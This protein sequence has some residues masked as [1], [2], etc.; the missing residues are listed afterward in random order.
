MEPVVENCATLLQAK[1]YVVLQVTDTLKITGYITVW[2]LST[3]FSFVLF[4]ILNSLAT[5]FFVI[6]QFI[7]FS[8][9]KSLHNFFYSKILFPISNRLIILLKLN[10][11]GKP[12][13]YSC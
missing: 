3:K 1:K 13:K 12:I 11:G 6:V 10:S 2:A 4:G 8:T 7:I 5:F 9:F